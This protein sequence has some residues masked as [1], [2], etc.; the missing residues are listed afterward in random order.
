MNS[1]KHQ[2]KKTL[3]NQ[4]RFQNTG[5]AYSHSI[6]SSL[7]HHSTFNNTPS[8][9]CIILLS[10]QIPLTFYAFISSFTWNAS[11][12]SSDKLLFIFSDS[13]CFVK[14]PLITAVFPQINSYL[15]PCSYLILFSSVSLET[16]LVI[17]IHRNCKL[18][19]DMSI[20]L[21]SRLQRTSC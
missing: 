17:D 8:F 6:C 10:L 16:S 5:Q 12:C 15:F 14:L 11:L 1:P 20:L 4:T 19:L 18:L 3:R 21:A 9:N 7:L 2:R 13:T